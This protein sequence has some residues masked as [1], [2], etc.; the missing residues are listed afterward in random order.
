MRALAATGR[1][2]EA[3]AVYT[4]T[5]EHLADH[6]GVSPSPGLQQAYLAI[7]RQEIPQAVPAGP[8]PPSAAVPPAPIVPPA[9]TVPP[10]P[11]SPGLTPAPLWL[12]E[13]GGRRPPARPR[14][15]AGRRRAS[16]AATTT[17]PGC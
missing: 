7:L 1:Q 5:R 17:S 8:P 11:P 9:P 3:L 10:A 6:L 16:S 4:R 13:T 14:P 2:A 12:R 15:C